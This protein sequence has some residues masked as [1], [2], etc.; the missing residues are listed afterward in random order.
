MWQL[1][2]FLI[3]CLWIFTSQS[4]C[5]HAI[6][7]PGTE[8]AA[9]FRGTGTLFLYS[10]HSGFLLLI[11]FYRQFTA[12]SMLGNIM[13]HREWLRDANICT[14]NIEDVRNDLKT[15]FSCQKPWFRPLRL[16]KRISALNFEGREYNTR[17][18]AKVTWQTMPSGGNF[19]QK[20]PHKHNVVTWHW[21]QS[22]Y[23]LS[24]VRPRYHCLR[25]PILHA[26]YSQLSSLTSC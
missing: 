25:F 3:V 6:I 9:S 11:F 14:P 21:G 20:D 1:F 13:A 7:C 5:L 23:W 15:P 17:T 22:S 18:C 24:T 12:S 4:H 19:Y 10:L 16:K 8:Q 2:T 26:I